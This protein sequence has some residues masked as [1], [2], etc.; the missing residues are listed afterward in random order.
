LVTAFNPTAEE[1]YITAQR[2]YNKLFSAV[3]GYDF[4]GTFF[5]DYWTRNEARLN[6]ARGRQAAA[7]VAGI[8]NF[9]AL[10][11]EY[12]RLK[13]GFALGSNSPQEDVEYE[14]LHAANL[15]CQE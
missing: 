15:Q 12:A 3:L 4:I 9:S 13:E 6:D 7:A 8:N 11:A 2:V 1:K 14:R 5:L 10:N